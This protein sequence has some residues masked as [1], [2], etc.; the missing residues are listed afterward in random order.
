MLS[1]D[2]LS[3][4]Y[5]LFFKCSALGMHQ[6]VISMWDHDWSFANEASRGWLWHDSERFPVLVSPL[7]LNYPC[8]SFSEYVQIYK[9]TVLTWPKI[10]HRN[11]I[12]TNNLSNS[13]DM[14]RQCTGAKRC[15]TAVPLIFGPDGSYGPRHVTQVWPGRKI[16]A[17][18]VIR[19]SALVH[20]WTVCMS[21]TNVA[22]AVFSPRRENGLHHDH[23]ACLLEPISHIEQNN[24]AWNAVWVKRA[25]LPFLTFWRRTKSWRSWICTWTTSVIAELTRSACIAIL[26]TDQDWNRHFALWLTLFVVILR[27]KHPKTICHIAAL[28]K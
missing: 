7:Q 11:R 28:S 6:K 5:F 4:V 25:L 12:V 26:L 18:A 9:H 19:C 10:H 17:T 2:T 20:G 23:C 13:V 24:F 27:Y 15:V 21:I 16:N 14:V 3:G 1:R 22:T 8:W